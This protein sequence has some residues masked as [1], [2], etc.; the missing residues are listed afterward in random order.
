MLKQI[1]TSLT[2]FTA[3]QAQAN[4][5]PFEHNQLDQLSLQAK[6]TLQSNY[7]HYL[8]NNDIQGVTEVATIGGDGGCDFNSSIRATPIQDAIDWTLVTYTELRIVEGTYDEENITLDDRDMVIRGGFASCAD[9]ENNIMTSPDSTNTIIQSS[10]DNNPV[11]R[12]QGNGTTN[13]VSF[14]N[15]SIS[16]SGSTNW[17]GGAFRINDAAADVFMQHV[18]ITDNIGLNGGGLAVTGSSG[19]TFLSLNQVQ[20]A[21]NDA[22]EGG[23]I[24]CNSPNG[25]IVFNA[26]D[27]ETHGI[28]NNIATA[29]DGG[30]VL[31]ENGCTFTNY[32]GS[33]DVQL[34]GSDYRGINFNS[35]TGNGGGLAVLGGAKAYLYGRTTC[36][37]FQTFWLCLFGNDDE[38]ITFAFNQADT[39]DLD[40]GDGGAIYVA[41]TD[42]HVLAENAYFIANFADNGGALATSNQ[43]T[44]TVAS[45]FANE[46]GSISCWQSGACVDVTTNFAYTAGGAFYA[47]SNAQAQV[48]NARIT[49]NRAISGVAGYARDNG[50]ILGFEG[51]LMYN[52]GDNGNGE[53]NDT[54]LLRSFL[55]AELNMYFSTVADNF[56]T[57]RQIGNNDARVAIGSSIIHDPTGV[58][59]Y[60]VGGNNNPTQFMDCL[61]THES[62]SLIA[63]RVLVTDPEFIDRANGNYQLSDTS[64]AIDYCNT[65]WVTPTVLDL[66]GEVR[67]QDAPGIIDNYGVYDVGAFENV[68]NDIIFKDGFE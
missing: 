66:Q 35:A 67:G 38:P 2:L 5:K 62:S 28:Y 29:G 14:Y 43:A 3:L 55:G 9:A 7:D 39:D 27:G 15:L 52:N 37:P 54:Y 34:F 22:E 60:T 47:E 48:N 32:Q 21:G 13:D 26:S 58:D 23:G 61:V 46:A 10:T 19:D 6:A 65:T 12:I 42:S 45:A 57:S 63:T 33:Q 24:Y 50:T 44:A 53:Y 68:T 31:I 36:V 56:V 1:L 18:S 16:N 20:I 17:F 64:S 11:F 59:I 40:G 51:A 49:S 41:G 4:N 30:G 25:S 8:L